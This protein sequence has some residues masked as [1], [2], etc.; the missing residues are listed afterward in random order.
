METTTALYSQKYGQVISA[1]LAASALVSLIFFGS[2]LATEY[3]PMEHDETSNRAT[4]EEVTYGSTVETATSERAKNPEFQK[5][6]IEL[7]NGPV[8]E[9]PQLGCELK[10]GDSVTVFAKASGE[11]RLDPSVFQATIMALQ[12]Y[13]ILAFSLLM[14]S[15][16]TLTLFTVKRVNIQREA[17]DA[18]RI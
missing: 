8:I 17:S 15:L 7:S 11:Q 16:F 2:I 14:G 9:Q 1:F 18:V 13:M 3:A 4:V 12:F 5:C 6:F 10:A